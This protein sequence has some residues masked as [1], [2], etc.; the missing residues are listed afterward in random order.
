MRRLRGVIRRPCCGLPLVVLLS[1]Q[2]ISACSGVELLV[3][4]VELLAHLLLFTTLL[5]ALFGLAGLRANASLLRQLLP[6]RTK[7][8]CTIY[9]VVDGQALR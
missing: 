4:G 9:T 3:Q 7:R 8:V 5:V 1:R 2:E 6:L